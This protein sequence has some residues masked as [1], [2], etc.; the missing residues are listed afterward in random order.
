MTPDEQRGFQLPGLGFL[1]RVKDLADRLPSE[2]SVNHALETIQDLLQHLPRLERLVADSRLERIAKLG[3]AFEDGRI[4]RLLGFIPLLANVPE[5]QT[6]VDIAN[7]RPY[8]A[9][10]PS[11][12]ELQA[13]TAKLDRLPS[14]E[15]L[16]ELVKL[17]KGVADF[18]AAMR[19]D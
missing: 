1:T 3:E 2:E 17:L 12:A 10:I 9:R 5:N 16:E 7:M 11:S 6:L 19:R 13:L 4:D 8:L 15:Q 14:P 18:A